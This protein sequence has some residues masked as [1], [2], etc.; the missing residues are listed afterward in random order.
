MYVVIKKIRGIMRKL[1]LLFGI[2][3][4][5]LANPVFATTVAGGVTAVGAAGSNRIVDTETNQPVQNAK[6]T[7]PKEQYK[8]YT[9]ANGGFK[10]G[11]AIEGKTI[12][13][14][15][16]EGYRPFSL[17]IDDKV[18]AK[19]IIVGI[20]RSN[21]ED[22]KLETQMV[23]LGDDNYS[24]NSA[25]SGEFKIPAAGPFYS[26]TFQ[27]AAANLAKNNFL[28]IGSIIGID[29]AMARSMG[30]NNVKNSFASPPEVF[31][32]GNKIAEIQLNGDGQRIKLP[33]NLIKAD[34]QN[35]ITIKTGR[36]LMQA[37]YIDYDDI[38]LMNLSVQSD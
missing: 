31:F 23:H 1:I 15:E 25:N 9:D 27:L 18:A 17:T 35:E 20:Q 11:T 19:P 16:K 8:T 37:A 10:L 5:S 4:L 30:Q 2:M 3:I 34:Q 28:I 21:L 22:I 38:E 13:S 33:N 32:N 6:I 26:K 36:N 24:K 12:M 7:I 29:S 14:V